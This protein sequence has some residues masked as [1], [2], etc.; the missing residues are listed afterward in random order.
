[1]AIYTIS[2]NSNTGTNTF[3]TSNYLG[4][5]SDDTSYCY[6]TAS[7]QLLEVGMTDIAAGAT[8]T[9]VRIYFLANYNGA[10]GQAVYMAP[11]IGGSLK[12]ESMKLLSHAWVYYNAIWYGSWTGTQVNA[13]SVRLRSFGIAPPEDLTIIDHIYVEVT[14]TIA[15]LP[16]TSVNTSET[17]CYDG[18]SVINWTKAGGATKYRIYESTT[19]G[20]SYVAIGSEL[21]DV[22][23]GPTDY[24]DDP[25]K[26]RYYKVKA[27]NV[28][29]WSALS[30]TYATVFFYGFTM[31]INGSSDYR[32]INFTH[33]NKIGAWNG[34]EMP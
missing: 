23:T 17:P 11:R 19:S 10:G 3:Y 26:T 9:A 25:P 30:T 20:G 31:P 12:S 16:P 34:V 7:N 32:Y 18:T 14:Y 27:G 8:V 28:A 15:P 24:E 4:V 13:M 6:A 33:I 22:A 29:G 1:M 2:V 5:I 21:G